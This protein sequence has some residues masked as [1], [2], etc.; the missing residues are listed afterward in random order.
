MI[1]GKSI[2]RVL[3]YNTRDAFKIL[4]IDSVVLPCKHLLKVFIGSLTNIF[5]TQNP[6]TI[7]LNSMNEQLSH[8]TPDQWVEEL[9]VGISVVKP[10][11]LRF[12]LH[13]G[14]LQ[15]KISN[16]VSINFMD[17]LPIGIIVVQN[18]G[19]FNSHNILFKH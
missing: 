7:F 15:F 12:Q 6:L 17:W 2:I 14:V 19:F 18:Q 9:R 16:K 3:I 1:G 13:N 4:L 10:L 8:S 11:Q 5:I